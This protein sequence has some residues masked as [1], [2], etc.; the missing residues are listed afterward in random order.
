VRDPRVV[1]GG[2]PYLY[3]L[4]YAAKADAEEWA[5]R[6]GFELVCIDTKV[7]GEKS[8]VPAKTRPC[9][10]GKGPLADYR[11]WKI[12]DHGE[13][14]HPTTGRFSGIRAGVN[15]DASTLESLEQI[16]DYR[17]REYPSSGGA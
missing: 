14:Y 7:T 6:T 9:V 12:T 8:Q 1:D 17:I 11:G 2:S 16:I 3:S 10:T 15:F 13:N 4:N 5:A